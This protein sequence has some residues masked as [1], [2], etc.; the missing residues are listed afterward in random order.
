MTR[1][2]ELDGEREFKSKLPPFPPPDVTTG[3]T[4]PLLPL[5]APIVGNQKLLYGLELVFVVSP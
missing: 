5:L 3:F 1:D 2:V 4:T